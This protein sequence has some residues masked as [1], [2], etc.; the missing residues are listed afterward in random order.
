M[1]NVTFKITSTTKG[2]TTVYPYTPAYVPGQLIF[3][4]DK[5]QIWLD[6]H[7]ERKQ[8]SGSR[9]SGMNYIG[10]STTNPT[11]EGATVEGVKI[12]NPSLND[13]VVYNTKEYLWRTG[14]DKDGKPIGPFWF[15]VGDEEVPSWIED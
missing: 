1:A 5:G 7:G 15:E 8:Y 4:E 2:F 13:M 3:L 14:L 10:I 9:G 11:T 12:T 6:F